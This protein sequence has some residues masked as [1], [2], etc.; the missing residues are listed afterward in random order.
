MINNIKISNQIVFDFVNC[1][2]KSYQ[3][4]N[5][6][7]GKKKDYEILQEKL[8]KKYT[9]EYIKEQVQNCTP[10]QIIKKP[11]F[12]DCLLSD[13]QLII[14]PTFIFNNFTLHFS[15]IETN[16]G[17]LTPIFI[18]P[19][20]K[21]LRI[22]KIVYCMI[23]TLINREFNC[24][25]N[26]GKIV[27]SKNLSYT[28][29]ALKT[30]IKQSNLL[31]KKF[32]ESLNSEIAPS[33]HNKNHCKFCE[34]KNNCWEK[35]IK[36]DDLSLLGGLSLNDLK[37]KNN[38][39]LFSIFQLSHTF[40]ARKLKTAMKK[41][42][43]YLELKALAL[44]EQQ[45]YVIEVP[46]I[47]NYSTEIY[48]DFESLPDEDFIYLIGILIK[49]GQTI[50]QYSFWADTIE[51]E[52]SIFEK[53]FDL[54]T[55]IKQYKIFHYGNYEI[56]ELEKFDKK[57]NGKYKENINLIKLKSLNVLNFFTSN[58]Y[59][60]VYSNSLKEIA[61]WLG[62]LWFE[63]DIDGIQ[64][65]AW[66]K[67]WELHLNGTT[68]EK[69]IQYNIEDCK[70]LFFVYKWLKSL[71]TK[72]KRKNNNI[73]QIKDYHIET[74]Y[75]FGKA[76]FS[77]PVFNDIN[78][79]AYFDYQRTKIF[80]R[81]NTR[82]KKAISKENKVK[83]NYNKPNK[84]IFI[85]PSRCPY[86]KQKNLRI[87][88]EKS[89]IVVNLKLMQS[90]IKKW[91]I[92]Y[93]SGNYYCCNCN[94]YFT[95]TKYKKLNSYGNMLMNW[96][97][98]QHV[99]YK[100]TFE[101]LVEILSDTFNIR[102]SLTQLYDFKEIL[103]KKYNYTFHEIKRS[104]VNGNLIHADE[105]KANV[106]DIPTGYIWVFTNMEAVFY[107]F[108]PDRT[109]GF[110]EILLEKFNGV[111]ISDFYSGYDCLN[112]VQQKCLVHLIRDMNED[113]LKYPANNE[114][115]AFVV[116]FGELLKVII[117][118]IDKYGLKKKKLQQHKKDILIFFRNLEK[119]QYE[120]ELMIKYKKRFIKNSEK[121]F[122]FIDYDNIPWNNNNAEHA[123]RPFAK[124]RRMVKNQT[125][126]IGL[127]RYLIILSIFQTCKYMGV[128]IMKFLQS[129][130][131]SIENHYKKYYEQSRKNQ[132][133]H[134]I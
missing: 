36:R 25:I 116:N 107:L 67:D 69:L 80:L 86:C 82:V 6:I 66:R 121:L 77:L 30:Y 85:K 83:R 43:Y 89:K 23:I 18:S 33:F 39:G 125:T 123:I 50:N 62:F 53:L 132:C 63:K 115:K 97:I 92:K 61:V 94:K 71:K 106:W 46:K 65:I 122:A 110:L 108:K 75:K 8:I 52:V 100:I 42:G 113:L 51:Q 101:Q 20:G 34:Y 9:E 44:R 19:N 59:P 130:D 31:L 22:Y 17:T 84:S 14:E 134:A 105:T 79:L 112:C 91:I 104:I 103:A 126:S 76:D 60:P 87:F 4:R 127:K 81:T 128:D 58:I 7:K 26:F 40:S 131:K 114:Y 98:Y 21:I 93:K 129:G 57:H 10:E 120:T 90:G 49:S 15:A 73:E 24:N 119:T 41:S 3:K 45:V 27:Y 2:Y 56:R 109:S 13:G 38:K 118:S 72:L 54:L 96:V 133:L 28:K 16:K 29:F 1:E 5:G 32:V 47:R 95:P 37:K 12:S 11:I 64:A 99:K 68:K 111:V 88:K 35:L 78:K 124:Y 117:D 102:I 70:A 55:D 74:P 48:M